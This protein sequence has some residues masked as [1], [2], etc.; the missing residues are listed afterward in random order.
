MCAVIAGVVSCDI[1]SEDI[2]Y[3]HQLFLDV[4][5]RISSAPPRVERVR[6]SAVQRLTERHRLV[7]V[8]LITV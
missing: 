2:L 5:R 8:S 3:E 7:S 6:D 4:L 1:V